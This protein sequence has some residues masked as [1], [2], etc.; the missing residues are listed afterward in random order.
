M[1]YVRV[2]H[3]DKVV[4]EIL[5]LIRGPQG[6]TQKWNLK[7]RRL[8]KRITNEE[9]KIEA[10]YLDVDMVLGM[11]IEEYKTQRR[12]NQRDLNKAFMRAMISD[13]G[14][15]SLD[16]YISLIQQG[17]PKNTEGPAVDNP[18]TLYTGKISQIRAYIFS[19]TS[20]DSNTNRFTNEQFLSGCNRF[21]IENPVPSVSVRCG[22][23][24]NTRDIMMILQ[25]AEKLYGKPNIHVSAK[26]FSSISMGLAERGGARGRS[27]S[28]AAR[29]TLGSSQSQSSE[30]QEVTEET[31][32][33]IADDDRKATVEF[34]ETPRTGAATNTGSQ[35]ML[36]MKQDY[37]KK[38]T[39][40]DIGLE[41]PAIQQ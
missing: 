24:G 33:E 41:N 3:H 6:D 21:S 7:I 39:S 11:M 40:T 23:Y 1:T 2:K 10:D 8:V 29:K 32:N 31:D 5:P 38:L 28:K 18:L 14:S 35:K 22:L 12:Q 19:C 25:E 17:L 20:G 9:R 15:F 37:I 26:M 34:D 13:V 30:K 4:K 36:D 27:P 16:T